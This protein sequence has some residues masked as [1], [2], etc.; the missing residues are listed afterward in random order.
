MQVQDTYYCDCEN[1]RRQILP[2]EPMVQT[3]AFLTGKSRHFHKD[4]HEHDLEERLEKNR[5][6]LKITFTP[7]T[8]T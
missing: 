8:S 4:C 2:T 7:W 5:P 6:D 3:N 1:C